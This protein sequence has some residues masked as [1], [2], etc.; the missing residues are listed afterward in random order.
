M[1]LAPVFLGSLGRRRMASLFSLLA[2]V[3]G[4]ALGMAVQAI[5]EAA[6]NEFGRGVR[7]LAG[8]AD[9][10]IV[11]PASGFDE[12]LLEA[13]G[14]HPEIAAAT[15]IVE[16]EAKLAG[17]EQPL[18]VLGVDIFT[19]ARV[20]PRLLPQSQDKSERF[21]TLAE[22][23]IFLSSAAQ[24]AY[25]VKVGDPLAMQDG[26][27]LLKL[28]VAGDLPG[29]ADGQRLAVMDIAAAQLAFGRLGKLSR[30]D[31]VV[32]GN[33]S[34]ERLRQTLQ[35]T[36]PAGV[37]LEAPEAASEQS[38][39]LTRAY[40]VN[41]SMLA[42]IALLTGAFLVFSAQALS[43]VKR[44]SEF[45]FLR[46]LGLERATL[47]R[48]LLAEGALVG[49]VGGVIGVALGYA[50]AWAALRL[51][52][53]D[54]GAGYFSGLQPQL[55]FKP[56]L[57]ALYIFLGL[58]A[59]LAGAAMPARQAANI[60]PAQA[61]KSA[62]DA[63]MIH[64]HRSPLLGILALTLSLAACFISPL[65]GLPVGG[66]AAIALLLAGS[67]LLLPAA[68]HRL[69]QPLA[70][71]G[72]SVPW[73]LAAAR[74][75]SAPGYAVVAA[76]GVL[77][78]V[79]LAVA[80]AIMVASFRESV[81]EW[82][83]QLLPADLYLRAGRAQSSAYMGEE[84]QAAIAR[85]P[86]IKQLEFTRHEQLRLSAGGDTSPAP[87]AL[88]ARP[89][90]ADGSDLP[91]VGAAQFSSLPALWISEAMADQFAWQRGKIVS[92]PLGGVAREFHV[93]GV[94]RDYS[95]QTGA[96]MIDLAV[97]R[98]MTGDFRVNDAAISL[99]DPSAGEPVAS[100]LTALAADD[101]L[102]VARPGEIRR[103]SLHIFDRTFAVTY[104]LEAVA[105]VI[106]LAG[107]AASFASLAATRRK[108]FGMLRHLGVS[109]AQIAGMLALEGGLVASI[110]V[111]GGL[112]GGAGIGLILIEVVNRQS[113][114]WSM[115]LHVP[116]AA[117]LLF[118]ISLIALASLAAVLAG[119]QA[120]RQDAVLAVREDW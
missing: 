38:G 7:V 97:Y 72:S 106:G 16:V 44:R 118:A 36:L 85:T 76:A 115:D 15:P 101:S 99:S 88:I 18:R 55:E 112:L 93:N 42:A 61:L 32:A 46:A 110:G 47:I 14:Q 17:H 9:L 30:I 45:A 66:Y 58:L 114:H 94:W 100:R 69:T 105:I 24:Q 64:G 89:V 77:T 119:R 84:L 39:N 104:L 73:R 23:S 92:L 57:T 109:R 87:V 91:L 20:A 60:A 103:L 98:Q 70:E 28:R 65:A 19:L 31:L 33:S 27:R 3:L 59:G 82:L 26:S 83:G 120:M 51:L 12:A 96:L 13:L 8:A 37:L 1:T 117:L 6:L 81:D 53:G 48:W 29:V 11:G 41:L 52:G 49:L 62:G 111:L 54:L 50:L 67:I 4:V 86:G 78:S 56:A 5:H 10:R 63:L 35:T 90:K 113:F 40:R 21:A 116:W 74:L 25:A 34:P 80:M 95:R 43:V 68:A 102:E 2:I 71:R 75:V 108:E 107:V 79:A 22:Q